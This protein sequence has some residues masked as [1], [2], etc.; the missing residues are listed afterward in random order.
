[1]M[2]KILWLSICLVL[3]GNTAMAQVKPE[4]VHLT[5]AQET[6]SLALT[7]SL[8]AIGVSVLKKQRPQTE[9]EAYTL[10][11]TA[12]LT[13]INGFLKTQPD[14]S[15]AAKLQ[16]V[17]GALTFVAMNTRYMK[18]EYK[19]NKTMDLFFNRF[20]ETFKA[21]ITFTGQGDTLAA[22]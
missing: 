4:E 10:L 22:A 20:I 8:N 11:K 19:L 15:D 16:M 17:R 3:V 14:A 2:F 6:A 12:Y 9:A 13:E 5:E 21:E 7:D 18:P 1:M